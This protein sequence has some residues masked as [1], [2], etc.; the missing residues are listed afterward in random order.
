MFTFC[1]EV[2][3]QSRRDRVGILIE[4]IWMMHDVS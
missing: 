4:I 2:E 1:L 3:W